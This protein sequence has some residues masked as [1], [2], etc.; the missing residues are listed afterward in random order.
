[1]DETTRKGTH[2][3][4]QILQVRSGQAQV[5]I[6]K[7]LLDQNAKA[8][9]STKEFMKIADGAFGSIVDDLGPGILLTAPYNLTGAAEANKTLATITPGFAGRIASA[10]AVV[11]TVASTG[12]KSANVQLYVD[13]VPGTNEVQTLTITGTPTGGTFTITYDGQTTA[14]I[15]YNAN[16]AAVQ[17]ALEA[18]SNVAV[19]DVTCGGGAL[20]GTP[21][22]IT[23]GG[24]LAGTDVPLATTTS[25]L[26]GGTAPTVSIAMTTTGDTGSDVAIPTATSGGLI[27]L[28]TANVTPTGKVLPASRVIWSA[29]NPWSFGATSVLS[30]RTTTAPTTF[31]EGAV[32]F[33]VLCVPD[34][35]VA[36]RGP[37]ET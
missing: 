19:G 7:L 11:T 15:A 31:S 32:M 34:V 30:F 12:G 22:T 20:P 21:V 6:N 28:T 2:P 3:M 29:A 36:T 17:S 5:D 14:A 8:I 26:T 25:S 27:Q 10:F 9:V 35:P 4:A 13:N 18:L 23:F 24:S 33:G 37:L 16:A 1:M